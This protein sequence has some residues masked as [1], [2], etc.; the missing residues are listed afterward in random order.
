VT[1]KKKTVKKTFPVT[2]YK[3]T[4]TNQLQRFMKN[5]NGRVTINS[6]GGGEDKKNI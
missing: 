6:K 4:L 3:K 5:N 1:E 2:K